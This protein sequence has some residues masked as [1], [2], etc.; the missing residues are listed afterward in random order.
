[1]GEEEEVEKISKQLSKWV[2]D[3]EDE[4]IKS[5][6]LLVQAVMK[7]KNDE[8]EEALQQLEEVDELKEE[9]QRLNNTIKKLKNKQGDKESN[10]EELLEVERD[11]ENITKEFQAQ[12]KEME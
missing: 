7:L 11:L 8:V 4:R 1:M 3:T 10:I 12:T 2:P 9:N 5:A 6:F